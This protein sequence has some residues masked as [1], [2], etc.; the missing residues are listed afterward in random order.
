MS[1][2]VIVTISAIA[3]GYLI[4]GILAWGKL[5]GR[6]DGIETSQKA[7]AENQKSLV[8]NDGLRAAIAEMKN[9]ISDRIE[10]KIE[11]ALHK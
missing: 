9:D 3:L 7:L 1:I 8:T 2:A 11:A 6:F 5:T 10:K 4:A